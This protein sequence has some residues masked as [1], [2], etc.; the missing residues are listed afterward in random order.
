VRIPLYLALP[1]ASLCIG[2][3]WWWGTRGKDFLTPPNAQT[4][5]SVREKALEELKAPDTSYA[6]EPT[7]AIKVKPSRLATPA[8]EEQARTPEAAAAIDPGDLSIAPA[9]DHYLP[10]ASRG[11]AAL[12]A[13]ATHLET[14]GETTYALLAWERVLDATTAD[15][16]QQD[17]AR[18]A[19]IRLQAQTPLWNVDPL[20]AQKISLHVGCDADR[21]KEIEPLLK[22]ITTFLG[23][24]SSGLLEVSLALKDG[25]K[26]RAD[27]P[28]PPLALSLHGPDTTAAAKTLTIPLLA[29][30]R[31]AQRQLLLGHIYKLIRESINA[32]PALQDIPEWSPNTSSATLLQNAITRR[33]WNLWWESL[34]TEAQ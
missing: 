20:T 31:D 30:E 29:Q 2:L 7:E 9:L 21:A 5:A 15:T 13:L 19:L 22:E 18:K 26:P 1:I 23:D 3:I 8:A 17:A 4:L 12:I 6:S 34:A 25:P 16:E 24:A 14:A 10:E 33:A 11:A 28:R 27:A 32:H